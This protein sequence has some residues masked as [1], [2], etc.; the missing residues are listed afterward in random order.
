MTR[1]DAARYLGHMPKTLAMWQMQGKGPRSVLVGGR[2]FYFKSDLDAFVDTGANTEP[3]AAAKPVNVIKP[4]AIETAAI[5][6]AAAQAVPPTPRKG[7]PDRRQ[8]P[9]QRAKSGTVSAA[10]L[11]AGRQRSER[12]SRDQ[13]PISRR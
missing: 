10:T 7:S 1:H 4:N 6:I 2:R 13:R 8:G 3:S 5:E 11:S 9:K 12:R